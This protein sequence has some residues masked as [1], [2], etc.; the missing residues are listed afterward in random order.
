MVKYLTKKIEI[1]LQIQIDV[2][3]NNN[4]KFDHAIFID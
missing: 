1:Y 3:K 4:N 2:Q